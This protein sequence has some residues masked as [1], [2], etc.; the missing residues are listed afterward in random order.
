MGVC[1]PGFVNI[2]RLRFKRSLLLGVG[3]SI[4]GEYSPRIRLSKITWT[5]T[6]S[7]SEPRSFVA[8]RG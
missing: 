4:T 7:A 1:P 5:E 2:E 3:R 8:H 6:T